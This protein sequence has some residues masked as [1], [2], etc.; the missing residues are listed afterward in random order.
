MRMLST[1]QTSVLRALARR[2]GAASAS[3]SSWTS[4]DDEVHRQARARYLYPLK[5]AAP[6][7]GECCG[8]DCRYC[9]WTQFWDR[10]TLWEAAHAEPSIVF[11]PLRGAAAEAAPAPPAEPPS[12][13][14]T[15]EERLAEATD[16]TEKRE[17]W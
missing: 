15:P 14:A 7:A 10:Q 13:A 3:S 2:S 12:P 8:S 16:G 5:P 1:L 4:R 17:K 6:A 11:P 9:V